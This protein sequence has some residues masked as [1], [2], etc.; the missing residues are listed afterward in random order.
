V[1]AN[2]RLKN[3]IRKNEHDDPSFGS[4]WG[5]LVEDGPYRK[6]L[7]RYVAEKDVSTCIAFAALLQ[8][9]TRTT[10]GLRCSGVGG[11]VCARHEL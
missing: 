10:T 6:H 7:A 8:K 2:F 1:D 9:D 4:G 3:R 11:V 5:Y